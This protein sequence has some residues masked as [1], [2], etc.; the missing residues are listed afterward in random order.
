MGASQHASN[1]LCEGVRGVGLLDAVRIKLALFRVKGCSNNPVTVE[2]L[3]GRACELGQHATRMSVAEVALAV[4][5]RAET[6]KF[7]GIR[8]MLEMAHALC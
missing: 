6:A 3:R 4:E 1:H 5:R 8:P 2:I 7:Q